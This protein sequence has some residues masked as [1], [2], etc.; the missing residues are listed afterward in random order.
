MK[1]VIYSICIFMVV[2]LSL[3]SYCI[4]SGPVITNL[5]YD[6]I[7]Q[8][9]VTVY[10]TTDSPADSRI[11]WMAPDSN[12]QAL[13]FTDS[14]Y[15]SA[16]VTSHVIPITNLQPAKIYKYQIASQNAGGTTLDSGYFITQSVSTGRVE[17]YFNHS[18]DTTVSTG[19]KAK[20]NQNFENLMISRIDSAQYSIDIAIYDF[21]YYNSI[22]T[23][24]INAKNRGVKIRFVNCSTPNTPLIDTLIA[25]GIPVIKRNYDTTHAMHNKFII[26]DYRYNTNTNIK[27]L[28]TGSTNVDHAQFNQD[29][30]NV[31]VIQDESLCALYTREFEE[32]WGSHTDM[33]IISRAKFGPMKVDN[34]PHILNVA[35]TRM[36][37]YFSPSDSV[38]NFFSNLILTKTTKSVFFCIYSFQLEQIE[39]AMH[40]LFNNGKQIKGVFDLTCSNE[41][42][43]V[44]RR[45]KGLSVPGAWNPPADVYVDSTTGLLHHK[46]LI[47]DANSTAGNKIA[48]TGSYNWGLGFSYNNDENLLFIFSPR[49]NNLYYQEFYKRFRGAGGEAIGIQNISSETP[50]KFSL[51]QNY[52]NPFNPTTNIQFSMCNYQFVTLKV[53]DMLGREIA[54]LVNEKLAPGS[55]KVTFNGMDYSSGVYFYRLTTNNF[56]D[57][58]R[59]LLIK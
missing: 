38:Q 24:I 5:T 27:F 23:A 28:W 44:F 53:F 21:E 3:N 43:T 42:R 26:F 14:I 8:T 56:T 51:S 45:M 33:P 11:R 35:G 2:F 20:G 4:A 9:G 40:T 39:D 41:V 29:R 49:V 48:V 30:N 55:Y 46:Y 52:P 31:I 47:I 34:V 17:V 13:I 37:V 10:W 18:V 36:E 22:A 12:Y 54:T 58:K 59:M 32:M 19:E 57:T 15:N 6:N 25:H 50:S 1:K 16:S 7:T